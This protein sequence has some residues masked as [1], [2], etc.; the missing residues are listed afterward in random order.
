MH[1]HNESNKKAAIVVTSISGPNATMRRLAEGAIKKS[2][3]FVVIGDEPSPATFE[4]EGCDFFGLKKQRELGFRFARQ[5]P[6]RHYARKNVGYLT[7]IRNGATMIIDTDDDNTPYDA[8]WQ[9]RSRVQNVHAVSRAG[10][11]NVYRYFSDAMI[12]PRGLP[13]DQIKSPLPAYETLPIESVDCP[14]QQGLSDTDPDVD[15]VYRLALPLPLSFQ[16]KRRVALRSGVWSPFNS[17]NTSWWVDA[18]PLL[19]LPAYCPF[20]MTDI[21]RSFVAQR[22]AW[23]ND[24]TVL[25]HEPTNQQNRNEHDLMHDFR[26]EVQGYLHNKA[27]CE[28]LGKLELNHSPDYLA[29]NLRICYEELVR[30][31]V[32]DAKEL[33]LLDAWLDDIQDLSGSTVKRAARVEAVEP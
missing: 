15:A 11:I 33:G 21:W 22:I 28:G 29:D 27:I 5:C 32:I 26:D 24:W 12:W 7:A 8:F 6:T 20:R 30:I 3:Q 14:I 13:L 18:F 2:W 1:S 9:S 4:L 16:H 25:F 10:W 23:T 19:Y 31:G 17:Q